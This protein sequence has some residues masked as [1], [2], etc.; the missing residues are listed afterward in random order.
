M[1]LETKKCPQ[2]GRYDELLPSN[3][4]LIQPTCNTCVS[5]AL[6]FN[7]AEHGDFFCRTYNLPFEPEL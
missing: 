6:D 1:E 4:P 2:C 3:N 7:N 5:G